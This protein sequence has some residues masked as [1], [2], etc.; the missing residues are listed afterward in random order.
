MKFWDSSAIVPLIVPENTTDI[1]K[2]IAAEDCNLVYWWGAPVECCSTFARLRREGHLTVAKEQ[3]C[4]AQ[5]DDMVEY[6]AEVEPSSE[7]RACARR[8]LLRHALRAADSLQ[9]AAALTW[10]GPQT[11]GAEFVCLDR[12]LRDAAAAEGFTI[13]PADMPSV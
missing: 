13:L 11:E 12:R 2:A 5:L 1:V 3:V 8:L 4:R 7:V 6:W 9:L 10:A